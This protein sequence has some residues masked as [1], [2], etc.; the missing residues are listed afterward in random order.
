MSK[1]I[2]LVQDWR[3]ATSEGGYPQLERAV[4]LASYTKHVEILL[5]AEIYSPIR[6]TSDYMTC[7]IVLEGFHASQSKSYCLSSACWHH[8]TS[9]DASCRKYKAPKCTFAE[10]RC[11]HFTNMN[12][13]SRIMQRP[14]TEMRL[15]HLAGGHLCTVT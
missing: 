11:S 3:Q 10:T 15:F 2:L 13:G 9:R 7:L 5:T 12:Y 8:H 6:L 4:R 1:C 14:Y